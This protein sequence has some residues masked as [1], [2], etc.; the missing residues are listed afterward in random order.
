MMDIKQRERYRWVSDVW[1]N[2]NDGEI[3]LEYAF[4]H[5][6]KIDVITRL[7]A[8]QTKQFEEKQT[9]QLNLKSQTSSAIGWFIKLK[10]IKPY[11]RKL[12]YYEV[13]YYTM[14][15]LI[16]H[17]INKGNEKSIKLNVLSNG[18]MFRYFLRLCYNYKL[19]S[20][21]IVKNSFS[22]NDIVESFIIGVA[23]AYEKEIDKQKAGK[24]EKKV[25]YLKKWCYDYWC[26][27]YF[28]KSC[29][30][31]VKFARDAMDKFQE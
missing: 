2:K 31:Y 30:P 24:T 1:D 7:K 10:I 20:C 29:Y 27:E 21:S 17:R 18:K 12:S 3:F 13:D 25:N 4:K 9:K 14:F 23:Q 6:L 28:N 8:K 16:Q 22:I 11:K 26:Q 19:N 5:S 15:R